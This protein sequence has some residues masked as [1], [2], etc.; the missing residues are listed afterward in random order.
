MKTMLIKSNVQ[1]DH[2]GFGEKKGIGRK[3]L[4]QFYRQNETKS[5]GMTHTQI[6]LGKN[7]ILVCVVNWEKQIKNGL[8]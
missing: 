3:C 1:T 7:D 4:L 6:P 2:I 8:R 5:S